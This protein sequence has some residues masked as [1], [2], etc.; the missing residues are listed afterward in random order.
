LNMDHLDV[1]AAARMDAETN[2]AKVEEMGLELQRCSS[3]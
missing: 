2:L 3:P 1:H